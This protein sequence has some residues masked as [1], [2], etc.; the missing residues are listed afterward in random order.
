[1]KPSYVLKKAKRILEINSIPEAITFAAGRDTEVDAEAF[2]YFMQAAETR[3][4]FSVSD[5]FETLDRA[6][7]LAMEEEKAMKKEHVDR[8][9]GCGA[10][11]VEVGDENDSAIGCPHCDFDFMAKDDEI[12]CPSCGDIMDLVEPGQPYYGYECDCDGFARLMGEKQ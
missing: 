12:R 8:C 4:F 2:S 1:M 10:E 7:S 9:E 3:T 5:F 6:I 11:W